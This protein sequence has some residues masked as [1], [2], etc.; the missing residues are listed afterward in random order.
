[1]IERGI[2]KR[3]TGDESR[4]EPTV[5]QRIVGSLLDL[6]GRHHHNRAY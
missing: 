3:A 5:S 4:W 1:M 2:G 6:D